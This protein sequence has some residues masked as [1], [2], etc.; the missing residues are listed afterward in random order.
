MTVAAILR[1]KGTDIVTVP[2]A[3]SVPDI[4]AIISARN[5]GAV[6]VLTDGGR[7][8]GIV[9]ERD[10]VKA[11]AARGATALTLRAADIMTHAVTTAS[12]RTTLREALELMDSRY[13]RHLPVV[14]NGAL[15]GIISVRDVVRAHFQHQQLEVD[16]L[17][18]YVFRGVL[19]STHH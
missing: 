5:I 7:L 4:A 14:E 9:S 11:V 3:A 18:S 17:K 12:P 2:C 15:L 10:V 16:S 19:A 8:A 13:C 6:L 1:Q